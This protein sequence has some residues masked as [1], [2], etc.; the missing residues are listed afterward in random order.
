MSNEKKWTDGQLNAITH[1]GCDLIVAAAAGSGKT[2]TLTERV[3]RRIVNG[4]CDIDKMLIVTFTKAAA[5]ELRVRI[6]QELTRKSADDPNDQS[7]KLKLMALNSAQIS[8]IHGF[9]SALIKENYASLGLPGGMRIAED[10]EA[11]LLKKRVMDRVIDSFY[12]NDV[13]EKFACNGFEDMVDCLIKNKSTDGLNDILISVFNK[14]CSSA[15][16]AEIIRKTAENFYN[17]AENGFF[18][19]PY[20]EVFSEMITELSDHYALRFSSFIAENSSDEMFFKKYYPA[21]CDDLSMLESVQSSIRSCEYENALKIL[22]KHSFASLGRATGE[23][24]WKEPTK[25]LRTRLKKDIEKLKIFDDFTD[26]TLSDVAKKGG[27]M[28]YCLYNLIEYF[29]HEFER[30][31]IKRKIMDYNDL[32]RYTYRLLYNKNA[33]SELAMS[34]KNKYS[35]IYVDEYQDCN[36]LQDM[37]FAALADGNRFMVGDIKQS[38]YSFRG[39]EPDLFSEYRTKFGSD[40]QCGKAIFLS[41]NFRCSE[42]IIDFSN[43]IFSSVFAQSPSVPYTEADALVFS[44]A[45]CKAEKVNL[46]LIEYSEDQSGDEEE[47]KYVADTIK[48]LI[49]NEKNENGENYTPGDFAILFRSVKKNASIYENEL[50]KRGIPV[51]NGAEKSFFESSEVLLAVCLLSAIDN[52]MRDIQLA[53]LMQSPLYKF[54]LDEMINIRKNCGDMPL[55]DSLLLYAEQTQCPKVKRFIEKLELY[56]RKAQ[57]MQTD[58]LVWYLFNDTGI[59]AS[60]YDLGERSEVNARRANLMT[61]YEFAR[62][63]EAGAFKGLYNFIN[64]INELIEKKTKLETVKAENDYDTSVKIMTI[65]KSKGLEFPV[66]FV[67]N[68]SGKLESGRGDFYKYDKKYGFCVKIRDE[69]GFAMYKTPMYECVAQQQHR[70]TVEEEGRLLY[71]AMTRA[72]HRLYIT[73]NTKSA[74]K[75]LDGSFAPNKMTPYDLYSSSSYIQMILRSLYGES[76]GKSY[77]M[78]VINGQSAGIQTDTEAVVEES[79]VSNINGFYERIKEN[80]SFEYPYALHTTLPKKVSVSR[81]YP[82]MLDREC[83]ASADREIPIVFEDPYEIKRANDAAQKGI[84]THL[85]MQFCDF[86]LVIKNGVMQEASR[87]VEHSFI[88]Q[89][90]YNDID[91]SALDEF[92]SSELFKKASFCKANGKF[93]YREYRF[94]I[95]LDASLFTSNTDSSAYADERLLVQG[96]VDLFFENDDG[97]LTLVDYKTDRI[98]NDQASIRSFI[99]RHRTQL[100]YYKIALERITKRTVRNASLYSFSLGREISVD[101]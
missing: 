70:K 95:Y 67:C 99:N 71:V 43:L 75:L 47:A 18:A 28:F 52:P 35:E 34:L 16:G 17:V 36:S 64:Y 51:Y 55:Y 13:P 21:L 2:A 79:N 68:A 1:T 84:A 91:F 66:C 25:K 96:V 42:N 7:L 23:Y 83:E 92:F 59:F 19:S 32:E 33:P 37:I 88:P 40:G 10:S 3:I 63:F 12:E 98:S 8:T 87:L 58:K 85:F 65:H 89:S 26:S 61:F 5:E 49:D 41:N 39:A 78:Q 30:E 22:C 82:D 46:S 57:S 94:N 86:D 60:V 72:R 11:L 80:L 6:R 50:K 93:F 62:K 97:T 20:S 31:K 48:H 54:T 81:L 15:Q 45:P 69:S 76:E 44:K 100:E 53:G 56:R 9:C 38:I 27:D 24:D 101:L 29:D 14:I 4:E 77:I 73:C 74:E 90:A